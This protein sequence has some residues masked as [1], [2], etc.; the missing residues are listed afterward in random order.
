MSYTGPIYSGLS[1]INKHI[2]LSS[3]L[4]LAISALWNYLWLCIISRW[5]NV[6]RNRRSYAVAHI[7]SREF[8]KSTAMINL[9]KLI[10]EVDWKESDL[11]AKCETA[12]ATPRQLRHWIGW[13]V[14]AN[15]LLKNILYIIYTETQ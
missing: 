6:R 1:V 3:S 12:L 5:S 7:A 4:I 11:D 9:C 14:V 8:R 15:S 2:L 10:W 13:T